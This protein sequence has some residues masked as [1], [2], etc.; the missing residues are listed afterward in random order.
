[1]YLPAHTAETRLEALHALIDAH[2]LGALVR[3]GA[4]GLDADHIPF[5]LVPPCPAARQ[6]YAP[7]S[8]MKAANT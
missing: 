8:S 1:M 3:A 7:S 4:A 2:P 6:K 5:E